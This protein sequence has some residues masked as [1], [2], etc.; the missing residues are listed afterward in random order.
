MLGS[1]ILG[2]KLS[3]RKECGTNGQVTLKWG[4]DSIRA[5]SWRPYL[6]L[7]IYKDSYIKAFGPKDH[8][9]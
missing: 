6:T 1:P 8:T 2:K 9:I 5:P 3:N 4:C 7:G